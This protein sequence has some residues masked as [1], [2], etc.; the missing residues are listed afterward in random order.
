MDFSIYLKYPKDIVGSGK[1]VINDSDYDLLW[2]IC[3][4]LDETGKIELR[5]DGFKKDEV[6]F[7]WSDKLS[8]FFLSTDW[9]LAMVME[10][11]PSAIKSLSENNYNFRI[12]F[13]EQ[14]SEFNL[15]FEEFSDD[16]VKVRY[17]SFHPDASF[18]ANAKK[19]KNG[20]Y[21]IPVIRASETFAK[22]EDLKEMLIKLYKDF[23]FVS[24][25][26]CGSLLEVDDDTTRE[27]MSLKS[28]L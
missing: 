13:Y 14:G 3:R 27:L 28:M 16:L 24:E 1:P 7:N 6:E 23:I 25:I 15:V 10:Q 9:D 4:I 26:I 2:A 5:M 20:G 21:T 8:R 11:L 19:D 17:E 18:Y 12:D 22:K